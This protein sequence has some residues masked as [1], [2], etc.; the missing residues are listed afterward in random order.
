M[1]DNCV[2]EKSTQVD[3]TI[4]AQKFLSCVSRTK[5]MF[6]ANHIIDVLRGSENK[7][8]LDFG[9]QHISTYGVGKEHSKQQWQQIARQ[10]LVQDI[11]A[12]DLEYGSLKITEKGAAVLFEKQKVFGRLE[13]QHAA[14][15]M[16]MDLTYDRGLFELLRR[17]RKEIADRQHV[18]PYV[19]FSDKTLIEMATFYPQRRTTLLNISGVGQVKLNRYGNLFLHVIRQYCEKNR[20]SEKI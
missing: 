11:L 13:E 12:K 5:E 1:C 14:A 18:P 2:L 3:I 16:Q 8:V 20:I 4:A 6:G 15:P 17:K 10:L 7:K 19:I 9:H